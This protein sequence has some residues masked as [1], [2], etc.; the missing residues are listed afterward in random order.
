MPQG[1]ERR[2][3]IVNPNR[4]RI[5]GGTA[6][7]K[8]I[9]SPDVYLRPMM[10]K[11]REALFSTLKFVGALEDGSTRVLDIFSGSGSIGLE[12]LSRGAA[13]ATFVDMAPNCIETAL[14][15]AERCGFGGQVSSCCAM[16]QDALTEPA[17]YGLSGTY[18]LI[19]LTPPY[20]EVVYN[21]LIN[22]VCNSP[23]VAED[24]L[25]VLEYPEEMGSLPPVLGEDKLFGVRNRKYGRTVLAVYVYRPSR[26]IDMRP[27]EFV[28]LQ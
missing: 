18:G 3:E 26:K 9:D 6:R 4:L 1:Q 10:A 24:T 11:V 28:K 16:A 15:N 14:E 13:H 25:V 20:E 17:K 12:A 19:T 8:K 23:L 22:A 27:D 5:T 7:G 2:Q 21:D